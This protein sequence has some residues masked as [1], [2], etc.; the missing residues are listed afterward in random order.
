MYITTSLF[1]LGFLFLSNNARKIMSALLN[2]SLQW[3]TGE[4]EV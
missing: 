2:T 3:M 1:F 4:D